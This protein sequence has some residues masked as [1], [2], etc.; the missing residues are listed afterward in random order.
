MRNW[1]P[2]VIVLFLNSITAPAADELPAKVTFAEHIAP[3]VFEQCAGCHRPGQVAPFSLLSYADTRKHAKTMLTAIQDRYMPPWQPEPGHGEFRNERRLTDAQIGLFEKWVKTEMAEGDVQKIPPLPKFPEGWRL[4]KPDLVVK[5]DRPFDVPADGQDIYQNFVIP[6]GV[7]EDKWVTAVE[8]RASAPEVVHHVLYFLDDSGR[9]RA[10]IKKDGQPGFSGMGFRPTG[11]LGGWAVGATPIRLPD[12]LAYPLRKKSDLVLQTHFHLSGKAVK[13]E[14]TVGIYFADKPPQR[15]LANLQLPPAFGIFSNVDI[16]AG[17]PKFKVSDS[18]TLPVDVDLVGAAAHAHYLGKTMK[19]T[20]KL[21]DGTEKDLFSIRD[22]D[23][24]WQGQYLYKEFVRLPKGTTIRGEVTWDNSANNPR[25]PVTPPVRVRWGESS[26][27]EMGQV[28]LLMVAADE[29]NK[30]TLRESIRSHVVQAALKSRLR[31]DKIEWERLGI[32]PPAFWKE[33]PARPSKKGLNEQ[34]RDFRDLDGKDWTPLS[35]VGVKAHVLF[36]ITTDCPISNS[37]VPEINAMTK[38][39]ADAPVRFFAIQVDPELKPDA[40]R[41]HAKEFGLGVP[42]LLDSKHDLV[43]A[44]GVTHTPEVA[45]ILRDGTIAYR[46]R[47]DDRYPSLGKKR[48]VASQKDL[49]DAITAIVAGEKVQVARTEAV[50][51]SIP[52]LPVSA[53]DR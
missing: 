12:G 45:L 9:A 10:K 28:S 42:V 13:E 36:F 21:P 35:V 50:G 52:D 7:D 5:M 6:L 17:Q 44:T 27:D 14:L 32:E 46:G 33:A 40:A 20:A 47:I 51:C 43:A 8:F 19:T 29:A 22:W 3:I 41:K 49:R 38:D 31:G 34:S 48:Q 30:D 16:P 24:N 18:F 4:G 1:L 2:A 37:Y 25:N 11:T 39:F 53:K 26:G 15:T 23:F